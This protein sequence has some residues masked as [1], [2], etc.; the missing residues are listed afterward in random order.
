MLMA[1]YHEL[2][3]Q[4]YAQQ[5][6]AVATIQ[7][8]DD[9]IQEIWDGMVA[10]TNSLNIDLAY[11]KAL[12]NVAARVGANRFVKKGVER[13]FFGFTNLDTTAGFGGSSGYRGGVFYRYGGSTFDPL[14]LDD[15]DLRTYIKMKVWKNLQQATF[16]YLIAF[17]TEFF[18]E[19][20]FVVTDNEDMSV[21]IEIFGTLTPIKQVLLVNY[22]ML[23]RASGVTYNL[24]TSITPTDSLYRYVTVNLPAQVNYYGQL[25]NSPG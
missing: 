2:L 3:I 11:G 13:T 10:I 16:P 22:D 9:A 5:P 21:D 6:K 24:N 7:G 23:P 19:N 20:N 12:D 15:V 25:T 18:G 1:K 8:F 17:L 4:Q 14:T